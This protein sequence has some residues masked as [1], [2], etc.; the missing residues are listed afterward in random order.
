MLYSILFVV[1]QGHEG[2]TAETGP[3]IITLDAPSYMP[4]M[5]HVRNRSLREEL[6]RAYLSRASSGDLDNT[7]IIAKTLQL[8]QEKAELLGYKN[9]GEVSSVV[10]YSL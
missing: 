6:Y 1:F 4:V 8:R 3:W 10:A 5:Q 7:P 2:A 9:H